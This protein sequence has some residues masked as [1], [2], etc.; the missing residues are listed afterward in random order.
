ME[1]VP[2][3]SIAVVLF[4]FAEL[5]KRTA[6]KNND[7]AK[8]VLPYICAILGAVIASVCFIVDPSMITGASN[9]L[10]ALLAGA[11]SGLVATG[12]HQIYKQAVK[13]ITVAH[14]V[15]EDI[16]E[17]VTEMTEDEKKE[18][19]TD[20]AADMI[21][22]TLNKVTSDAVETS[23]ESNANTNTSNESVEQSKDNQQS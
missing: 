13:L 21:T 22:E 8:A 2:V 16:K 6:M 23:N 12:S 4:V 11:I 7:D 5:L 18:Y 20:V 1:Y 15:S 9:I 10:E 17:E 19:L 14:S 3:V